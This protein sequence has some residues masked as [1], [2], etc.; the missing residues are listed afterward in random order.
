M[1]WH[2]M[3]LNHG[4]FSLLTVARKRFLWAHKE[5]HLDPHTVIGLVLQVGGVQKFPQALGFKGLDLFSESAGWVH[6]SQPWRRMEVTEDLHNLTL[7][8]K[9]ML[10]FHCL[11]WLLLPLLRQSSVLQIYAEQVSS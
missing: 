7:L 9:L 11:I 8:V 5:V 1:L 4:S 6:V 3:C 10:L 2:V